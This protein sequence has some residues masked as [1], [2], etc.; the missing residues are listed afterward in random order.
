MT[1]DKNGEYCYISCIFPL[2][3]KDKSMP[4]PRAA[5]LA[6]TLSLA[7]FLL[8][9]APARAE[10]TLLIPSRTSIDAPADK[11]D[12]QAARPDGQARKQAREGKN[13]E[14]KD[15]QERKAAPAGKDGKATAE[16]DGQTPAEGATATDSG[17]TEGPQPAPLDEEVDMLISLMRPREH[18]ALPMDMPQL[19]AA[20]RYDAQTR[21]VNGNPQPERRDLLGDMEE[22]LYLDV[23]AWGANVAID[24]AG[25]YQ[26]ITETRP[27]YN[28]ERRC[29]EQQYVKSILP[30]CGE[31][32]G[33]D[34]RAGLRLEILPLIRPFGLVPGSCFAGMAVGPEGPLD[35]ARVYMDRI[36]T[37]KKPARPSWQ[38][39]L[40]ARTDDGGRFVFIPNA[41]GWWCCVV[42][43]PGQPL[44][45]PDGQPTPLTVGSVLWLYVDAQDLPEKPAKAAAK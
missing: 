22:S 10:V 33:W 17:A 36:R 9:T 45:G 24:K 15:S 25:L 37:E 43:V 13:A 8:A 5:L 6:C 3:N 40:E 11:K 21:A 19:F 31:E 14:H 39:D 16:T 35:H 18:A 27:R 20:L 1:H 34:R 28:A 38:H 7:V 41:P 42:E 32:E 44:K 4:L 12:A 23:R 29:F 30:V 2:K 26:F